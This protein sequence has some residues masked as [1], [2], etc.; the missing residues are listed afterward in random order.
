MQVTFFRSQFAITEV[1]NIDESPIPASDTTYKDW[2]EIISGT[3]TQSASLILTLTV[4]R[5]SGRNYEVS[6]KYLEKI[7]L[8]IFSK[9][10]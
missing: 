1:V 10:F 7:S 4:T 6:R 3:N 2:G 9:M 5:I 8:Q